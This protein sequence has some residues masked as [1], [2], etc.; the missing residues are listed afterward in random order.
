MG[1]FAALIIAFLIFAF[2]LQVDFIFYI[3]YVCL[4]IYAWSRWMTPRVLQGS[5]EPAEFTVSLTVWHDCQQAA[6]VCRS[7]PPHGG[8]RL[9]LRRFAAPD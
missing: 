9:S 7:R 4:G 5:V 3:V 1:Q 2:F 8:A 6:F